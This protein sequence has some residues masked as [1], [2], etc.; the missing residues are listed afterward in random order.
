VYSSSTSFAL[1]Y[2]IVQQQFKRMEEMGLVPQTPPEV[3]MKKAA[4]AAGAGAAGAGLDASARALPLPP[5]LRT[6]RADPELMKT[7]EISKNL[8]NSC[9][10]A[11]TLRD[12]ARLKST[13]KSDFVIDQEE[14]Q[15]MKEQGLFDKK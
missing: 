7:T 3:R 6:L 10:P 15:Y 1:P 12:P 2:R 11:Y 13:M 9:N 4:A 5:Q 8:W 14:L